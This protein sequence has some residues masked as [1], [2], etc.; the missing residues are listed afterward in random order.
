V[1]AGKAA[2]ALLRLHRAGEG[3]LLF[4]ATKSETVLPPPA[5]DALRAARRPLVDWLRG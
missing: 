1:Y 4:W 3:P 5:V 2:A